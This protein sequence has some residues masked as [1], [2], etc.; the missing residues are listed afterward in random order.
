MDSTIL[1]SLFAFVS[2]FLLFFGLD[3][4][5]S[6]Q[7]NDIESRLDRYATRIAAEGETTKE[8]R[9]GG[10]R[11]LGN[12]LGGRGSSKLAADL[13]RADLKLTPAEF[14]SLNILA[15]AGGFALLF[16]LGHGNLLFGLF[17]GIV[18]F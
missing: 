11:G 9:R 10:L 4:I 13:A 3:R 1:L 7:T 16:F 12:A 6:A 2:V 17:G 15:V 8:E 5:L 14:V 18:G